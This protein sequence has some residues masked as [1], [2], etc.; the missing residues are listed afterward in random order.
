MALKFD[1]HPID[2]AS[3][4]GKQ[5]N[6]VQLWNMPAKSDRQLTD[7]IE[8][9]CTLNRA[10]VLAMFAVLRQ[11]AISELSDGNKFHIPGLGYFTLTAKVHDP[12]HLPYGKITGK[13]VRLSGIRFMPERKLV[14]EVAQGMRFERLKGTSASQRY[15]DEEMR[16]L[17]D[18]YFRE[19]R[20]L[21]CRS[22]RINFS[23]SDY[24]A[25]KWLARLTAEGRLVKEGSDRN[26]VYFPAS[27]EPSETA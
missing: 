7:A 27:E 17:L 1:V 23:L 15:T 16:S 24:M 6:Y 9:T 26:P 11:F 22:M 10:D 3:G 4:T 12:D 5:R 8:K 19:N 20:Y 14:Q 2:N 13:D 25:R 18:G 21:T